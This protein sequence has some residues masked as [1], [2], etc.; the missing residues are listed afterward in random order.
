MRTVKRFVLFSFW[1]VLA[2]L[3]GAWAVEVKPLPTQD[4]S[5]YPKDDQG[6]P[7]VDGQ[8]LVHFDK[9]L[10]EAAR[11]SL[12]R[13]LG[14]EYEKP[15]YF[16]GLVLK[17]PNGS[18]LS[19][20]GRLK[21][22]TSFKSVY[23]NYV[24]QLLSYS[25]Y[26]F[27]NDPNYQNG[28]DE[29]TINQVHMDQAWNSSDPWIANASLGRPSAVIAVVDTG[30]VTTQEDF[31][32]KITSTWDFT[33][34]SAAMTDTDGHGTAVAGIAG[35]DV[36][37]GAGGTGVCANCDLMILR[38]FTTVNSGSDLWIEEAFNYAFQNGART[39]N[40]SFKV[41]YPDFFSYYSTEAFQ[42]SDLII[43]GMGNDGSSI[44]VSPA[45]DPDAIGVGAVD[46][47]I[48]RC[49]FSNYGS[50]IGLTVPVCPSVFTTNNNCDTCYG[51]WTGTSMAAPQVSAM[52]AILLD[53]GLSPAAT[54]QCLYTTATQAGASGFNEFTGWG[55]MNCYQALAAIRP[56]SNFAATGGMNQ[57]SL[58]WI[59]P[60][61]TAFSTADYIVSRSTVSGGP[62]NLVGQ[63]PNGSTL[64]FND[65]TTN[66]NIPY[67]YVV[68]AVDAQGNTTVVSNES[69][70]TATGATFTPTA[71]TTTTVTNT[72]TPNYGDMSGFTYEGLWHV[73]ND[74]TSPCPNSYT[75]P[76][77]AYWGIDSQCNFQSG[78][79]SPS[80]LTC[81]ASLLQGSGDFTFWIWMDMGPNGAV[82]MLEQTGVGALWIANAAYPIP[83]KTWFPIN[84]SPGGGSDL[85]F[86]AYAVSA[87]G[88][89]GRG[90]YIDDMNRGN[91][92]PTFTSTP[93]TTWPPSATPTPTFDEFVGTPSPS[94]TPTSTPTP[95]GFPGNTCTF[96]LT[97]SPTPS[98]TFT[99]S[100]TSTFTPTL[101]YTL[102]PTL[103]PT[104]TFT[105]TPTPPA[106]ALADGQEVFPNP[107]K[108]TNQETFYYVLNTSVPQV[109]IKIFTLAFRKV[110]DFQGTT[111]Q[112]ANNV[113]YDV[114]YLANGLYY[115]TLETQYQGKTERKIGKLLITR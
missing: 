27:P 67:Y 102:T 6:R 93:S 110:A 20:V 82:L 94:Y 112:G 46:A 13:G 72:P 81:P 3:P 79:T 8:V 107:V 22:N 76:W 43:G 47:T 16:D 63:T 32:G 85:F 78:N 54:K 19:H 69:S 59:A 51:Y 65:T 99:L 101:T 86:V 96:T 53:L 4:F 106:T 38:T 49:S 88:N 98:S 62:Y 2:A 66:P 9:K 109:T 55:C 28:S 35:A 45:G 17:V 61:T 25:P 84:V 103:T 113:A 80:T 58:N 12:V 77:A 104:I 23:P 36:N 39:V 48:T 108:Y 75:P 30:A 52:A 74:L 7:Y 21:N 57:V 56:A 5:A 10:P 11:E 114:S 1:I 26:P 18:V 40:C 15:K 115:Y 50:W 68:Q 91:P 95:C 92:I 70:A 14:Y 31:A 24:P 97:P 89:T 64:S 37:N 33:T 105:P 73:V 41:D 83:S 71:T 60:Q 111:Q 29:W 87:T 100:P 90:I 34:N 42:N 44:Q